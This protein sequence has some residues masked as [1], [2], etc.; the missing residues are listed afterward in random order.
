MANGGGCHGA[1]S[2]HLALLASALG[3]EDSADAHFE[4]AITLERRMGA[5]LLAAH[6]QREWAARLWKRAGPHEREQARALL[7]A[8]ATTYRSLGLAHWEREAR[9]VVSA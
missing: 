2:H 9:G 3:D 6:S 5:G 4:A 7:D 8:A 1:V